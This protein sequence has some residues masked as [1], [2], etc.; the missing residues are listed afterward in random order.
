MRDTLAQLGGDSRMMKAGTPEGTSE[1][2]RP[3]EARTT[4]TPGRGGEAPAAQPQARRRSLRVL[5]FVLLLLAG[6]ALFRGGGL[7][8]P[9]VPGRQ[10]EPPAPTS[11]G[12]PP[13]GT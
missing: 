9:W 8:G 7:P 3:V 1:A 4:R 12:D 11:K 10:T 2:A 5:E 13:P 6:V